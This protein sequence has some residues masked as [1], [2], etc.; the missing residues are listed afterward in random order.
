MTETALIVPARLPRALE[1]VRRQAVRD[2]GVGLPAHVTLLYPFVPPGA[3]D[4]RLRTAIS[5]A[6]ATHAQFSYRLSGPGLWPET[7]YASVEPEAPFRSLY[8]DLAAAFPAF[9]IYDG[10]FDFVPHVT[11]AEGASAGLPEIANDPAWAALPATLIARFVVLIV[12]DA[13]GWKTKWRFPLRASLS[14]PHGVH[15]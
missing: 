1:A 10:A 8:D 2:A 12:R 6:M 7:L 3:L 14:R 13:A 11:I 5:D 15:G 4:P 9:P